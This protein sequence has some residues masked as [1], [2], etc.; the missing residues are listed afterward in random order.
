M[1]W[2]WRLIFCKWNKNIFNQFVFCLLKNFILNF[3]KCSSTFIWFFVFCGGKN[4]Y[5]PSFELYQTWKWIAQIHSNWREKEWQL[6]ALKTL[7][8]QQPLQFFKVFTIL[9]FSFIF[10]ISFSALAVELFVL[11]LL[12]SCF[13]CDGYRAHFWFYSFLH[14]AHTHT[15]TSTDSHCLGSLK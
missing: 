4:L 13:V 14:L 15:H 6:K 11:H 1:P 12:Y 9:S 3:S 8:H 5:V 10:I 7:N 2:S